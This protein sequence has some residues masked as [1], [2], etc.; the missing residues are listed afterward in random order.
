MVPHFPELVSPAQPLQVRKALA[1]PVSKGHLNCW[2]HCPLPGSFSGSN[3]EKDG[4]ALLSDLLKK[5]G[6]TAQASEIPPH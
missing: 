2:P 5:E 6:L 1:S 3:P 4:S